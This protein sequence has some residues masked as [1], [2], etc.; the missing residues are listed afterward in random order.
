L[1]RITTGGSMS[2]YAS[3]LSAAQKSA[4]SAYVAGGGR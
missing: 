3:S 2:S 4:L 1:T